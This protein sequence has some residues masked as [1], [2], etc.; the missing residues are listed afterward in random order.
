M[1]E[2]LR[3]FTSTLPAVDKAKVGDHLSLVL[4]VAEFPKDDERLLEVLKRCRD[5][6]GVNESE[7]EVVECQCLGA[8]VTEVTHDRERG[9]MLFGCQFVIACT[10]KLRSQLVEPKRLVVPVYC[11]WF[12][13]R[14][15]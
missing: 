10:S 6:A 3:L 15:R 13:S 7:S 9:T 2:I 4:L 5:A 14:R 8:P 1:E 12:P 11:G